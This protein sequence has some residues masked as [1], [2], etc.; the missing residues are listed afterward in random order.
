MGNIALLVAMHITTKE[1]PNWT[2]QTF[3]WAGN[4]HDALFGKDRP[5]SIPSPW[6]H[7]NM[8][9]AYYM[10]SPANTAGAEPLISYKPYLET[11]IQGTVPKPNNTQIS[12]TG[13][14]TNCMSCPR[15]AGYNTQGYQPDGLI[16]PDDEALFGAGTKT[17]FLWSIPIL[18]FPAQ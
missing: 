17:D 10:V 12:W 5:A 11:N 4:P 9:T 15:M 2:W 16:L 6:N 14:Y 7:Y 18:A 3:W 13:V 8:R 1:T